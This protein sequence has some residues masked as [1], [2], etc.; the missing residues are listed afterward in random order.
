[1][2]VTHGKAV[3]AGVDHQWRDFEA[4]EQR[5]DAQ[6]AEATEQRNK[7]KTELTEVLRELSDLTANCN[8]EAD[9]KTQLDHNLQR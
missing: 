2:F 6:I 3:A 4:K 8:R 1:M 5:M 7:L 9:I